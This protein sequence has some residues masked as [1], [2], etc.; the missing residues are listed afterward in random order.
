MSTVRRKRAIA[1]IFGVCLV[2]ALFLY[3]KGVGEHWNDT[4]L[5]ETREAGHSR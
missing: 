2:T 5:R 4:E 1:V 3:K